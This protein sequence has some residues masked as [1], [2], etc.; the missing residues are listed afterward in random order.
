[1]QEQLIQ[2]AKEQVVYLLILTGWYFVAGLAAALFAKRTRIDAWCEANPK[3]ALVLNLLR[4]TGFDFWKTVATFQTLARAKAGLPPVAALL[5]VG[6]LG[7]GNAGCNRA[8]IDAQIDKALLL[9]DQVLAQ[10][11][12]LDAVFQSLVENPT[13]TDADKAMFRR[14]FADSKAILMQ[15]MQAK[16]SALRAAKAA[17]AEVINL[18]ELVN[19]IV[20]AV[21]QIIQVV[22]MVGANP[23]LVQEQQTRAMSLSRGM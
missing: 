15:A 21:Q 20:D 22:A 1:M 14:R 11:N 18:P 16:D 17:N 2:F 13:M 3:R 9:E 5:F 8:T 4:A 10:V 23:L 6:L 7:F 19:G 12:Y